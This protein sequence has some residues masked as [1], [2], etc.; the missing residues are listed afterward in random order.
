MFLCE[1]GVWIDCSFI[2]RSWDTYTGRNTI[3]W[4]DCPEKCEKKCRQ[5]PVATV[6]GWV[7]YNDLLETNPLG[8]QPVS[9]SVQPTP[10]SWT[11]V[12]SSQAIV[13]TTQDNFVAWR[14]SR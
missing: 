1:C 9:A 11:P 7:Y 12:S 8:F 14:S 3:I 5:S 4:S 2:G 6:K 10:I 13:G